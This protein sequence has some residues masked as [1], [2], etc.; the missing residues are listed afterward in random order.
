MKLKI[1]KSKNLSITLQKS[2]LQLMLNHKILI[3]KH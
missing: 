2:N 3:A 1:A